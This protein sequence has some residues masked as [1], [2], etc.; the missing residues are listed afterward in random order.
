[1]REPRAREANDPTARRAEPGRGPRSGSRSGLPHWRGRDRGPTLW[2]DAGTGGCARRA[3]APLSQPRPSAWLAHAGPGSLCLYPS[4]YSTNFDLSLRSISPSSLNSPVLS[5]GVG[6][7]GQCLRAWGDGTHGRPGE[8]PALCAEPC[9]SRPMFSVFLS[10]HPGAGLGQTQRGHGVGAEGAEGLQQGPA[11]QQPLF[12]TP[13]DF[14]L[15]PQT[16]GSM[17]SHWIQIIPPELG[18]YILPENGSR[19]AP[20]TA[21]EHATPY[22]ERTAPLRRAAVSQEPC[23]PR[24]ARWPLCTQRLRGRRGP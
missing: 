5:A 6:G 8:A 7:G 15:R 19:E 21:L 3:P 13:G 23:G 9:P 4:F 14:L 2:P 1:M 10:S 20:G 12:P 17:G 16:S 11:P 18:G 22:L 24:R